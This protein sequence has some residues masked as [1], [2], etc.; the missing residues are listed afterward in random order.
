VSVS[1]GAGDV[2]EVS[3]ITREVFGLD[4][5]HPTVAASPF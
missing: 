1:I 4:V 2:C 5:P 3:M